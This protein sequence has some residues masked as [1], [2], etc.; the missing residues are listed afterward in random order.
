MN[1]AGADQDGQ[2][3]DAVRST[4]WDATQRAGAGAL[5]T[6]PPPFTPL[7]HFA[8]WKSSELFVLH[9]FTFPASSLS[10]VSSFFSSSPLA[11]CSLSMQRIIVQ[12]WKSGGDSELARSG[13][14]GSHRLPYVLFFVAYEFRLFAILLIFFF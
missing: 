5:R 1:G 14:A 8:L 3:L 10:S 9:P 6:M 12:D 7:R 4:H 13:N 11:L 2:R